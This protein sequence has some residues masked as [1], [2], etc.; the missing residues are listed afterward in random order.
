MGKANARIT[1]GAFNYGATFFEFPR[2]FC[3]LKDAKSSPV[4]Y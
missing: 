1:R 2:C 4:F 3:R